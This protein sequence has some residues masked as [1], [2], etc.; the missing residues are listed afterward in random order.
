MLSYIHFL[1]TAIN[2]FEMREPSARATK[3][4][5]DDGVEMREVVHRGMRE[6]EAGGGMRARLVLRGGTC[7]LEPT[8]C[9]WR[10]GYGCPWKG[11]W[12]A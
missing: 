11:E 9:E 12:G 2:A 10:T 6:V 7:G 5:V 3:E 8:A 4:L 1:I